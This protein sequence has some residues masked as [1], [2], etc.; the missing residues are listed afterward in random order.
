MC[1]FACVSFYQGPH[2][3][4]TRLFDAAVQAVCLWVL[5]C[6]FGWWAGALNPSGRDSP[7][8]A[9]AP[10]YEGSSSKNGRVFLTYRRNDV[11]GGVLFKKYSHRCTRG[12]SAHSAHMGH[13]I[14]ILLVT[15]YRKSL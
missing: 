15:L 13:F 8:S 3:N 12:G 6:R 5:P 4:S 14:N 10:L 1:R 2:N 9:I 11:R 7:E